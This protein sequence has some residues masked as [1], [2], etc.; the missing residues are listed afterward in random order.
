LRSELEQSRKAKKHRKK[1]NREEV[2]GVKK[3]GCGKGEKGYKKKVQGGNLPLKDN[4][5]QA[6]LW[7]EKKASV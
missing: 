3:K 6:M 1:R 7:S 4:R 5:R 2:S